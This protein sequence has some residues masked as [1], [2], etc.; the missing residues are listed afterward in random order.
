MFSLCKPKRLCTSSIMHCREPG[1]RPS[2]V[3][4]AVSAE[5]AAAV[6]AELLSRV[7]ARAGSKSCR[8]HSA[9]RHPTVTALHPIPSSSP[10]LDFAT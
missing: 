5:L 4:R 3:A 7:A 9:E 1:E 2:R 8:S 10:L 6:A